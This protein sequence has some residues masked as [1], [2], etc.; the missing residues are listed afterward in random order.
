MSFNQ[1]TLKSLSAEQIEDWRGMLLCILIFSFILSRMCPYDQ[2]LTHDQYMAL[3]NLGHDQYMAL[4]KF[5]EI[6]TGHVLVMA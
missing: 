1:T 4:Y 6:S 3:G 5:Y 2:L